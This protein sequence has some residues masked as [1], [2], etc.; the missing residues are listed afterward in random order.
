VYK[1]EYIK[2]KNKSVIKR[3]PGRVLGCYW[4]KEKPPAMARDLVIFCLYGV[5][6]TEAIRVLAPAELDWLPVSIQSV[7]VDAG[8]IRLKAP[9]SSL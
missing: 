1:L 5:L 7:S 2:S 3:L 9:G 4:L 6:P 8:S